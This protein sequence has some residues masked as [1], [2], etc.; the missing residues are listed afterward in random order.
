MMY[1]CPYNFQSNKQT[2]RIMSDPKI[3]QATP[4]AKAKASQLR[5][6]AILAWI[7]AIAGEVFAI[8]KLI[9]NE[10]LTWLIVAIVAIL[11]LA[12]VGN[13]LWKKANR[14]DPPSE[15]NKLSFFMKSQLG[16]IM[17]ALAFL[18]LVI[19]IFTNKDLDGKTKGI[20]GTIAIVALLAAGITG[21][22]FNPAS[23][24]KY[25]EEINA[26]TDSLKQLTGTDHV[27]W[28]I[29]GNKY[30]VYKDCHHIK[31]SEQISDGSIKDAWESRK[32]DNGELCKTCKARATKQKEANG[33][34][35][36]QLNDAFSGETVD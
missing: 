32:I 35:F 24:E 16:V 30:H 36:E 18:P 20:A 2:Y 15:A 21:V 25:T 6:F 11:I 19:L 4:E 8:L 1:I 3:F 33:G 29:A 34:V 27:Y 9:N 17:T 23:I 10:T 28:S 26:Q 14:L 5:L 31:N 7:V 13:L 12:V 22:D